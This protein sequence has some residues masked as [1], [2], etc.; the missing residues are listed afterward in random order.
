MAEPVFI[1]ESVEVMTLR[2]KRLNEVDRS[3]CCWHVE[4]Q[5]SAHPNWRTGTM[6]RTRPPVRMGVKTR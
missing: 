6:H 2:V 1:C 5:F 4:W 3:V